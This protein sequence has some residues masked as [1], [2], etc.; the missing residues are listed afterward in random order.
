MAGSRPGARIGRVPVKRFAFFALLLAALRTC[1]AAPAADTLAALRS[2]EFD[3]GQCYRVREISFKRGDVSFYLTEGYLLLSK[4]VRGQ[5]VA[6][7]FSSAVDGG[8]AEVIM[9]PPN[10][11]ERRNLAARIHSPNL[12]EHIG[13]AVFFFADNTA[14]ELNKQMSGSEW[15]HRD[16]A[17]GAEMAAKYNAA[18]QAVIPQFQTALLLDLMG[19]TR[20]PG[21]F[22][23]AVIGGKSVGDFE[24]IV[25]PHRPE[26]VLAG[27]FLSADK[28]IHFDIWTS[29]RPKDMGPF[30]P[31]AEFHVDNYRIQATI[32]SGLHMRAISEFE[33]QNLSQ[34]LNAFEMDLSRQMHV[35]SAEVDG[36]PAEF[37]SEQLADEG[38][39]PSDGGFVVVP[40]T[41]LKAGTTHVVR[42]THSG[43]VITAT[44]E[45]TYFVNSRGKWYPHRILEFSRFD[46]TFHLPSD[47]DLVASGEPV[48]NSLDGA[49]RTIETRSNAS[50]PMVGF[51]FGHYRRTTVRRG[52]LTVEVCANHDSKAPLEERA[53]EIAD[54]MRFYSDRFG[55]PPLNY[56]VVSPIT[57]TFGQ[58][59]AGLIYLST[60]AYASPEDPAFAKA[61]PETRAFFTKLMQAHEA[62]HQW[63]G[64]VVMTAGYHDEWIIEALANFSA[65]AYLRKTSGDAIVE[66]LMQAY[67]GALLESSPSGD[68]IESAGPLTQGRRL[69]FDGRTSAWIAIL[70]GKGTWVMQMLAARMG[71]EKFWAMLAEMRRRY[72]GAGISTEQFRQLCAEFMPPGSPDAKLEDFFEQWVWSTG[73]PKLKLTS[74]VKSTGRGSV[75]TGTLEQSDVPDDFSAQFPVEA[76]AGGRKIVRWVQSSSDPVEFRWNVSGLARD[77]ALD[78]ANLFLRR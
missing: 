22:F 33:L 64:N 56:L 66:R 57:A 52:E 72:A 44:P 36:R 27:Q 69:E 6:A 68:T 3:P 13:E 12:D 11:D 31:S 34:D 23:S 25:N 49:E 26:P 50:V 9:M 17:H 47:F 5:P 74:S 15:V 19:E 59:F 78:P 42:I 18:I 4:P 46:L 29:Y 2:L 8:D 58:G 60:Y 76:S 24:L 54:V 73:I 55:P 14:A 7:V 35:L 37:Q 70:Y 38:D 10:R 16:P 45:N 65:M 39:D 75:I 1:S 43:D 71:E 21:S 53:G 51:N 63:W 62:A 28:R 30:S 32:D 41:P 67:R 61:V 48:R 77:V 40:A 20:S